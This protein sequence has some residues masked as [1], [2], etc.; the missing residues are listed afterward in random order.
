M[1]N[2]TTNRLRIE[3]EGA[4]QVQQ[5]MEQ[6]F[7]DG[8]IYFDFNKV[9]L[10]PP[11]LFETWSGDLGRLRISDIG[12]ALL[13]S[14]SDF[15]KLQN[16]GVLCRH[17]GENFSLPQ[18]RAYAEKVYPDA[19][20]QGRLTL[21]NREETGF[22]NWREWA[23]ACWGNS[24]GAD[25]YQCL[26]VSSDLYECYFETPWSPSLPVIAALSCRFPDLRFRYYYMDEGGA[27]EK[28]VCYHAGQETDDS[29]WFNFCHAIYG[30]EDE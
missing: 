26:N 14:E 5:L 6:P 1:A 17:L 16:D 22:D 28:A 23:F 12:L 7:D 30:D 2:D 19:I 24:G 13:G 20:E 11:S 10:G 21:R 18:L 4:N 25:E 3:G 9:V 8:E 15:A 29:E 27:F